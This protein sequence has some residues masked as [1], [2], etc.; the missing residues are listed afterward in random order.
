MAMHIVTTRGN[1]LWASRV[2]HYGSI[3]LQLSWFGRWNAPTSTEFRYIVVSIR[4]FQDRI[5]SPLPL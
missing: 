1:Q 4:V 5:Q 2:N 3:G